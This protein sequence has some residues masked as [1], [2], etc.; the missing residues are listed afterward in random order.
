MELEG[1]KAEAEAIRAA[2]TTATNFIF[3]YFGF[4]TKT[5]M[6]VGLRKVTTAQQFS[7][8]FPDGI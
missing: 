3:Q 5:G 2:D 6:V 4:V 8:Q 7:A 1:A